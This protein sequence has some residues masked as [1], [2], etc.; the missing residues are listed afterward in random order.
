MKALELRGVCK[1]YPDFALRDIEFSIQLGTITGL[2]GRNGAGKTTTIKSIVG[3]VHPDAGSIRILGREPDA[4]VMQDVGVVYDECCFSGLLTAGHMDAVLRDVY[5]GWSSDLFFGLCERYALPVNQK[6]KTFSRGMKQ[7]L[8][9]AAALAHSPR[10]LLLDEPTGGL[11]PVARGEILDDLREF[12]EDG[13]HA[14]LL[15]THIT[16][17]LDRLADRIVILSGGR[18]TLDE[19][20]DVLLDEYGVLRGAPDQ[21]AQLDRADVLGL[22]RGAYAF[23]ALCPDRAAAAAR[24]PALTCDRA[25]IE[26]VFRLLEGGIER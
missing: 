20:K 4:D 7:K 19:S 25:D 10:L 8:S 9:I 23:E 22:R 11:D 1:T 21:L 13:Q 24:Y 26:Q 2:V 3:T 6:I 17:D 15:S 14:V 16:T 12:I 18:L 5:R